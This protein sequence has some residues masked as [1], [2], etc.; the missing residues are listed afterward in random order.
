MQVCKSDII[1]PAGVVLAGGPCRRGLGDGRFVAAVVLG[2]VARGGFFA[3]VRKVQQWVA[4]LV[5]KQVS[6]NCVHRTLK[7]LTDEGYIERVYRGSH[8]SRKA[9]IYRLTT[10]YQLLFK[11]SKQF[12]YSLSDIRDRKN[13]FT[14]EGQ[15]IKH[16]LKEHNSQIENYHQSWQ[17][18]LPK[19]NETDEFIA[20]VNELES[21]QISFQRLDAIRK[22]DSI[23]SLHQTF[24]LKPGN[25][26]IVYR[27]LA[28]GRIQSVPHTYIGK[29]LSPFLRPA[30][31]PDLEKGL[32][33]SLDYSQQELRLLAYYCRDPLMLQYANDTKNMFNQMIGQFQ[34][35]Q[36]IKKCSKQAIYSFIYGSDGWAIKKA[37]DKEYGFDP[38]HLN[39]ARMFGK[40]LRLS[41]P[42]I[43]Y[44][45]YSL[46]QKLLKD[47]NIVAP[48]GVRR[49]AELE[50]D[51][52]T[53][54]G[55]VSKRWAHRTALSH[56]IQGAGAWITRKVV[57]AATQLNESRLF[58]PVH[59]GFIFY[60]Q[61]SKPKKAVLEA[62]TLMENYANEVAPY[63]LFPV[64]QEWTIG[65]NS[66]EI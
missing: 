45:Q 1:L 40:E 26:Q 9:S 46:E 29:D 5:H 27:P 17:N 11:Q 49:I 64:K 51:A 21:S 7:R 13:S 58:M 12:Y 38:N 19:S 53:N 4:R 36:S 61:S 44:F 48:G 14:T 28:T 50:T 65:R 41:F 35:H 54:K 15:R 22:A 42:S 37:L 18:M 10:K 59:D 39:H 23:S 60:S 6:R 34:M 30:E 56:T 25:M 62:R 24:P 20:A 8:Q 2:V 57:T 63:V 52:L 43:E 32:L 66:R 47:G 3:S 31:D 33:F 55:T 16:S